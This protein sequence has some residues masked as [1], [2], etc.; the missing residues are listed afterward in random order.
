MRSVLMFVAGF[1][2]GMLFLTLLFWSRGALEAV[3]AAVP[4][5]AAIIPPTP[6]PPPAALSEPSEAGLRAR[7]LIVPVLHAKAKNIFD[8]FHQARDGRR[9]EAVDIVAPRGTPVVATDYGTIEKLFLSR[10]GGLTIY[11]FDP[12]QTWSYYYAHLDR[13]AEGLKE[14]MSVRKGDVL[15]YVGSTGNA[16][17]AAPHLH[18]AIFKLGP[19]KHWWQGVAIDPYPILMGAAR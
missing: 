5:P 13:Y 17:P 2:A 11:E 4:A 19:E 15:G 8:T 9:H 14:G 12:T 1:I 6:E 7:G 16:S 3:S 18:F 10:Q